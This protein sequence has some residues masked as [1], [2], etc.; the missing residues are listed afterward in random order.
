M[1]HDE[2][3]FGTLSGNALMDDLSFSRCWPVVAASRTPNS[4]GG[5]ISNIKIPNLED[6]SRS[7]HVPVLCEDQPTCTRLTAPQL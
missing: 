6:V 4:P 2:A 7:N 1:R 3:G 5:L